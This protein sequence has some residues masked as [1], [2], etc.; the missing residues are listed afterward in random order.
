MIFM[1]VSCSLHVCF[2]SHTSDFLNFQN[3]AEH[4]ETVLTLSVIN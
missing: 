2:M 1:C 3:V 4:Y